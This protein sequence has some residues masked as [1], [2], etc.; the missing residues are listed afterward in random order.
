MAN[1][2]P[3]SSTAASRPYC[4]VYC[5]QLTPVPALQAFQSFGV[6]LRWSSKVRSSHLQCPAPWPLGSYS[7]HHKKMSDG[8]LW[9]AR[10]AVLVAGKLLTVQASSEQG[11]VDT[12]ARTETFSND[13]WQ[14]FLAGCFAGGVQ[15]IVT[16]PQ[17]GV[18]AASQTMPATSVLAA[19]FRRCRSGTVQPH[20]SPRPA[21]SCAAENP[22]AIAALVCGAEGVYGPAAAAAQAGPLRH[23]PWHQHH[24]GERCS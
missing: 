2:V 17:E 19:A 8:V 5:I 12:G 22:A 16:V 14:V 24:S 1:C 11:T 23:V 13:P 9:R 21:R 10:D 3:C 15:C 20:V 7:P 18:R 4:A 6:F